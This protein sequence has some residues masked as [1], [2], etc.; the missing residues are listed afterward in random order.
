MTE[1][2]DPPYA[3]DT[4]AKGWR[5]ELD[6][7]K[8]EQSDTWPLAAELPMCQHALLMMW[9]VAWTQEPCGSFTN[10][11]AVIRAKCRIPPR[12]WGVCRDV[13]MRG[14]TLASDGRLYHETITV[15]VLAM[16]DKRA[17][18]AGRAATR[19]ARKADSRVNPPG[20]TTE[21]RVTP[22]RLHPKSDTNPTPSTKHQEEE[23]KKEKPASAA[24]KT[25]LPPDFAVS[26]RV[27]VWAAEKGHSRLDAQLEAFVSYAK[28][29]GAKYADWDEALMT[30]I[31]KDWAEVG[32]AAGAG[33]APWDGA[34]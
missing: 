14:W 4:R 10:D 13:L 27:R 30:A 32:A 5:F 23:K 33:G 11:E 29:S 21:S 17:G 6:Y 16:L 1:L 2:P 19:R 26:E 18:D 25:A 7:E 22:L 9:L 15:R 12:T 34:R 24:R 31:R 28:R 3:A 8:I 20:V